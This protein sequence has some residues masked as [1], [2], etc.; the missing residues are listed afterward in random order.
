M[1]YSRILIGYKRTDV[2]VL[3]WFFYVTNRFHVPVR[4]FNNRSQMNSKCG[5][6]ISGTHLA[7]ALCAC[8]ILEW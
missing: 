6:N 3:F 1:N 2:N 7:I 5:K 8:F 4:L